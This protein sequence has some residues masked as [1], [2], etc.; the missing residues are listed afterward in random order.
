[1]RERWFRT[2]GTVD[3]AAVLAAP[4]VY[5]L[6]TPS[7]ARALELNKAY[8]V[9]VAAQDYIYGRDATTRPPAEVYAHIDNATAPTL[10]GR[11]YVNWDIRLHW[12]AGTI[13][14][15]EAVQAAALPPPPADR[16]AP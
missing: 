15:A 6:I 9:I 11:L 7:R 5:A 13:E 12:P 2:D 8:R 16:P 4:D 3:R 10:P 1:M 14:A